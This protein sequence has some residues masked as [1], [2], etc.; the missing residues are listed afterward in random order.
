MTPADVDMN[1]QAVIN[2]TMNGTYTS[3]GPVVLTHELS[4]LPYTGLEISLF[5]QYPSI[6]RAGL[7]NTSQLHHVRIL[8]LLP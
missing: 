1:Y 2:K 5:L 7:T 8:V 3:Y 6:V 4:E